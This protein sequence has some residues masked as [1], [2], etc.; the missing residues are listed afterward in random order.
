MK[1]KKRL[2]KYFFSID[3]PYQDLQV[4]PPRVARNQDLVRACNVRVAYK[5]SRK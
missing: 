3:L 4:F 1:E 5:H 2:M